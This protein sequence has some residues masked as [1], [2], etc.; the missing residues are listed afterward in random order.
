MGP[1]GKREGKEKG[2]RS[3][4]RGPSE[5]RSRLE[6]LWERGD[7]LRRLYRDDPAPLLLPLAPPGSRELLDR[8]GEVGDWVRALGEGADR[9]GYRI[10]TRTVR[11]R[12]LGENRLPVA[13]E[14]SGT[15]EAL[16]LLGRK[17]AGERWLLE[18]RRTVR[19]FPGLED[20]ILERPLGLFESLPEWERVLSVLDHFRRHPRPDL[21]LRQLDIPGVDTKFV[22]SRKGLLGI[23]LDQVLPEE[24]ID[25]AHP[26]SRG[27]EARYGL[28][29]KPSLVRFRMLDPLLP[30]GG[31]S[32]LSVPAEE[33][34]RVP[35]PVSR[36]YV[37][38]NEINGLAFPER[39]GS[40]V[41]FGLGYAVDRL[42]GA[43][44]LREREMVYWG[45]IDTHGFAIL[46]RLR[47]GFPQVRSLLMDRETFLR[48]QALLVPEP[49]PFEG[50]LS[51]LTPQEQEVY[52]LL[53]EEGRRRQ[54]V[55]LE[56][57]RI[58]YG[59]VL[60]ALASAQ[61]ET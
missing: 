33:F 42:F 47:G 51:R 56:Q 38:E 35:L 50:A 59:E 26:G 48:H 37:V 41:I 30:I 57:E 19:E 46:D 40:L 8:F 24:A 9:D 43:R 18:A 1:S 39:P 54:A 58:P 29:E 3:P 20:W 44:W 32:D 11:H 14:F 4:W 52:L 60:D 27:F 21:Y 15:R 12:T 45:D 5:I 28:R 31:F 17:E 55:R 13:V 34:A 6:R 16:S 49:Q 36:V 7:L 23:L 61:S 22:E 2:K 10:L 53:R 25:R